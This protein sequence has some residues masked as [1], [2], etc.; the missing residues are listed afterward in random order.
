MHNSSV[1]YNGS[2]SNIREKTVPVRMFVS[3]GKRLKVEAAKRGV[4]I[5]ELS[6]TLV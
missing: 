3:T 6:D 1:C 5:P 2:M 4:T